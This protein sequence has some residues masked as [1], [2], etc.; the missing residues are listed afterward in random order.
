MDYLIFQKFNDL[1]GQWLWLDAIIIFCAEFLIWF[2]PLILVL[3]YF[4]SNRTDKNKF[5]FQALK[6]VLIVGVSFIITQLIGFI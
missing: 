6:F 3:V 2:M 4:L 5:R 1:A